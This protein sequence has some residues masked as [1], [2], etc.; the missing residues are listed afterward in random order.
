MNRVVN[1]IPSGTWA[2][3]MV[4]T[5]SGVLPGADGSSTTSP[6]PRNRNPLRASCGVR[7]LLRLLGS[8]AVVVVLLASGCVRASKSAQR[9][10]SG[11]DWHEFRGTWTAAGSRNILQLGPNRRAA[12]STF[13]GSLVLA[14]PSR[15]GVGFRSEAI[16]FN[17]SATGMVGRAVWTDEHGDQAFSEL[18]G[19]GTADNNKITGTFVGGTG[20]YAGV[21]GTYEFSWRFLIE[22]EDG[23]VQGQSV[24]LNGR[25]RVGPPQTASGQGGPQ[26]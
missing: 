20:R 19:E 13:N 12:I 3:P 14:G 2:S 16:V 9:D 18:H 17:D 7:H 10:S 6:G 11:G 24:G 26:S 4:A 22:N 25:V 5:R 8:C 21:I 15:P 23:V 1:R